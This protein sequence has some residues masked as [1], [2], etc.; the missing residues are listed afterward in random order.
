MRGTPPIASVLVP[1]PSGRRQSK[2]MDSEFAVK[3]VIAGISGCYSAVDIL[4][5]THHRNWPDTMLDVDVKSPG[6]ACILD[7][8]T[9]HVAS[10]A[11]G[12]GSQKL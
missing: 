1:E 2:S 9:A 10:Q 11:S 12:R 5:C 3:L 4:K 7:C 8:K 6:A